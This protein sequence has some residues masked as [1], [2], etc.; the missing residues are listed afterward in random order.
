[1]PHTGLSGAPG[2]IAQRLVPDYCGEKITGPSGVKSGLSDVKSLHANGHLR[3]QIQR[4]G[5][6]DRGT[7]LSSDPTGPSGVPQRAQLFSNG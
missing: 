7:E 5:A 6:P 1:V 3:C 2:T 4:P